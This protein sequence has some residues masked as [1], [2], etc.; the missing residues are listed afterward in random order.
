MEPTPELIKALHR[1]KIEAAKRMSPEQKLA[2]GAELFDVACELAMAGIRMQHPD[3]NEAQVQ[4]HLRHRLR[5]LE[6]R[7]AIHADA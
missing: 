3:A 1:D 6:K 2:A 7:S 5:L 4:E